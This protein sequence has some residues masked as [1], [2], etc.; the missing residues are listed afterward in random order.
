MAFSS[1]E[2]HLYALRVTSDPLENETSRPSIGETRLY[3]YDWTGR[4]A[5]V[6]ALDHPATDILVTADGKYL[7]TH[8][9]TE[10]FDRVYRYAL[11]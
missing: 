8:H 7:Y 9:V 3:A 1:T 5:R 10:D 11:R 2:K 6:Y 4:L